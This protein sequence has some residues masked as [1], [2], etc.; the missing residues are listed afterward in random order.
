M[1]KFKA[2]NSLL[3]QAFVIDPNQKVKDFIGVDSIQAVHR[4]TI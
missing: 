1:G 2:E 4:F 3:E